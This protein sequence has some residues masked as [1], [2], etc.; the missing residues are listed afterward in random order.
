[1]GVS[2]GPTRLL[3][4]ELEDH[5]SSVEGFSRHLVGRLP[6]LQIHS[7]ARDRAFSQFLDFEA[8]SEEDRHSLHAH[9]ETI[10]TVL[11]ELESRFLGP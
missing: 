3:V 7:S 4:Q 10:I 8:A 9:L 6:D 2:G 1:M 11:L 5:R